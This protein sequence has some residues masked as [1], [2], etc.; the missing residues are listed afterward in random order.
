MAKSSICFVTMSEFDTLKLYEMDEII[1]K[2][3]ERVFHRILGEKTE[4]IMDKYKTKTLREISVNS[5][6]N[7][8]SC[9]S[10]I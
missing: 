1:Y 3:I 9:F 4:R 5:C 7:V 8:M 2:R 10:I 6:I